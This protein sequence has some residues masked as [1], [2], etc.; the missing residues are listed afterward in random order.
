MRTLGIIG[1]VAPESTQVYYRMLIAACRERLG[2]GHYPSLLINSIDMTHMLDLIG[3]QK[4]EEVTEF[5]L[6]EIQRLA[7]GGAQI[8]LIASNTPHVVFEALAA[9][10]PIPLLS[11]VE[12]ACAAV[13]ERGYRRVGLF[14][15]RFT[16]EGRFYP[17]VFKR[18]GIALVVP[19]TSERT[20]IHDLY[21]NEL[22]QG[23]LA[24]ESRLRLLAV[25][26]RMHREDGIQALI[27][28]GTELPLILPEA[29]YEGLPM[30]DTTAAHVGCAV[31]AMASEASSEPRSLEEVRGCIDG[32]DRAIVTLLALRGEQV[33]AA[34]RFKKD[35]EEVKAP[36]RVEQ[37]I[38]K[39]RALAHVSGANAEVVERT[40]R[41]M[42]EAFIDAELAEHD[43]L[44]HPS[45]KASKAGGKP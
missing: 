8:G 31:E 22:V 9:R 11:I 7:R 30:L 33:A 26:R 25:A 4:L 5:L 17:D 23:I 40:Y 24:P 16:M 35:S 6:A 20:L 12:A 14:G 29:E 19:D 34:A 28:G 3:K 39:V 18:E 37:V 21:M 38:A 2:D 44:R 1:G 42:I 15:T 32:L 13:R 36:Q 43:R 10:S 41:A 27:L 45:P